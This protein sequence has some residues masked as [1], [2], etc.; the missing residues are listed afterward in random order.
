MKILIADDHPLFRA[1]IRHVLIQLSDD[2]KVL[3]A[4]DHSAAMALLSAH[5]DIALALLDLAMPG[6]HGL[7][8]LDAMMQKYPALPIVIL[9]ASENRDD[10]QRAL[11]GG[12]LGFIQKSSSPEIILSALRLILAGG[13]Y[14]PQALVRSATPA[15]TTERHAD[16]TP[17]QSAVLSH[18]IEGKSNKAIANELGL[19]EATVKAHVTGIFKALRV[20]NRMQAALAVG[21]A[22]QIV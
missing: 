11:D 1:G 20:T 16:L 5:H 14:V 2:P 8:T 12:A 21:K 19:T 6:M 7:A 18:V 3:E 9:S 10:M 22:T 15:T 17:R 4:G 13:V